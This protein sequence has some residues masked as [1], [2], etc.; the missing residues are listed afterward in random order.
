MQEGWY[1]VFTTAASREPQVKW[2]QKATN[3]ASDVN[4]DEVKHTDLH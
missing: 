2:V 4:E 3:K 1:T